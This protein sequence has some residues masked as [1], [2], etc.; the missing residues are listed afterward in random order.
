M[1]QVN[2]ALLGFGTVGQGTFELLQSNKALIAQRTGVT[3]HVKSI[4]VRN[5]DKYKHIELPEGTQF[6]QSV[7]AI[8]A[9]PEVQIIVEVMGGIDFAKDCIEKAIMAGKHVATA[10]K[11]LLADYG[12]Y[13]LELAAKQNVDLRYEA[14]VLGG[15]PIIRTLYESLGGNKITELVGILNGTTNFILSNMTEKGAGY[16]EVLKEAQELGYA[17]ADPTSDVEG[18]DAARKLA[19]LSSIAFNRKL[20]FS[21]VNVEGI[22]RIDA[23]DIAFGKEFGYTIKLLGIAK[24]TKKGL[25]LNVLPAFISSDHPLASVRSSYN[26][27]YVKGNG[28]GDA[29]FYGRGAGSLPTGSSVVSDIM[30]IAKNIQNENTGRLISFFNPEKNLYA[31]GKIESS[32]Y[33]RLLVDNNT[34]VLAKVASKLAE[35]RISVQSVIQRNENE[36]FATL[37]IV[38]AACPRSYILNVIDA[39]KNLRVVRELGSVIRIMPE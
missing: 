32:H 28:I 16:E 17:E 21:D 26:A 14:S 10:N 20:F 36:K 7:D 34:G 8:L 25:S 23:T 2:V 9:D 4:F 27:L 18:Y 29:M 30:E 39:F 37:A 5:A 35:Q 24:E 12:P 22:T 1:K 13:L 31:P 6:I 19:I 38:T 3:I 15:I 11:D 33:I